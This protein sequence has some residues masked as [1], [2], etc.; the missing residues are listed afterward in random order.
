LNRRI[1]ILLG[2]AVSLSLV[3]AGCGARE[4]NTA[5]TPSATGTP[6]VSGAPSQSAAPATPSPVQQKEMAIKAYFGQANGDNTAL[7]E[8]QVSIK[9]D[10]DENKYLA[11][12]NAL[13]KNPSDDVVSLCP[14]TSFLSAKL[15]SGKLSV[16][17]NLP[18][19]DRLGSAGEGQLL[20]AFR[21]TLFQF[22]EVETF[23]ILVNGKKP[24]SLM[25]HFE[26]PE[27]FKR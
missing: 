16:N 18:D 26:L 17:L 21:K 11:A 2:V 9:F 10:K 3:S 14:N 15:D 19:E 23:E 27:W 20:D 24:E 13:K 12:L 7:V 8:K 25:G 6:A 22:N 4:K 1:C 5:S